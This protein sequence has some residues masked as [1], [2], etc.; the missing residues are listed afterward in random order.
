MAD[1][2]DLIK[3]K[4]A[5]DKARQVRR[6]RG[7]V[8]TVDGKK[9]KE[10]QSRELLDGTKVR[11]LKEFYG[12]LKTGKGSFYAQRVS[13][14]KK[15]KVRPTDFKP[16]GPGATAFVEKEKKDIP[17]GTSTFQ[18]TKKRIGDTISEK[19]NRGIIKTKEELRNHPEYKKIKSP[20]I[21]ND[22]VRLLVSKGGDASYKPVEKI[23]EKPVQPAPVRQPSAREKYDQQIKDQRSMSPGPYYKKYKMP[24]TATVP[25]PTSKVDRAASGAASGAR[26]VIRGKGGF[27]K[28]VLKRF[29]SGGMV[30]ARNGAFIEIENRFSKRTLPGKKRT[31]RIY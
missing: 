7:D 16:A 28:N 3:Q 27:G 19:I 6:T 13:D 4:K 29:A 15:I 10:G 17:R 18:E 24:L 23:I 12:N 20:R 5:K 8:F 31:T 11:T 22:M 25:K 9:F 30:N 26:N 2:Q 14:G 1:M 21:K